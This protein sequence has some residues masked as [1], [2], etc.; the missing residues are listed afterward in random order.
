MLLFTASG[1]DKWPPPIGFR[2]P[3]VWTH[4]H[5][6]LIV[7]YPIDDREKEGGS[8][9]IATETWYKLEMEQKKNHK[10]EVKNNKSLSSVTIG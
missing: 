10:G 6:K 2:I 4:K 5:G 9:H 3:G 1:Y 8:F 7:A